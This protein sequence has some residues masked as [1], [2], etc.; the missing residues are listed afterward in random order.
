MSN[1]NW[2]DD[3]PQVAPESIQERLARLVHELAERQEAL[4]ELED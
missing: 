3:L 4:T 1:I 2:E